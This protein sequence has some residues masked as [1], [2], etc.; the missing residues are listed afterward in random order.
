MTVGGI[1]LNESSIMGSINE[2]NAT[3]EKYQIVTEDYADAAASLD[4]ARTVMQTKAMA[5]DGP[6]IISFEGISP[7]KWIGAGMLYNMDGLVAGDP[8]INEM[9]F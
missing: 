7:L 4:Q 5:G 6:D 1:G 8:D 2:F 9:I 3:N